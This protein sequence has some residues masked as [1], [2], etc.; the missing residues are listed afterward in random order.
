MLKYSG[1][2]SES[3]HGE[4]M[5]G[6]KR[7]KLNNPFASLQFK[8][9]RYYWIGMCISLVGTWMQNIAQPWLAYSLTKS[10]LLLSLVGTLQF[11]PVLLFSLF[12]GVVLDRFPKK[13]ILVATQ[14]SFLII[15]M[16]LT[17]L[18]M[19]G[20]IRYWHI[21]VLSTLMGFVNTFD[22]PARQAFVV[23]LIEK[24]YL[25]NAIS[26]NSMA[27]NIARIIG[28]TVAGLVMGYMGIGACFLINSISFG[29][30]L[31]GLFFV[32]PVSD[33]IE[34]KHEKNIVIIRNIG[35]GLKYIRTNPRIYW[36]LIVVAIIG[37][38]ALNNSVLVPVFT[39]EVLKQGEATFG[40]ILSIAGVGSLIG[41]LATA[42]TSSS[43]PK[44]YTI[45]IFPILI[46]LFTMLAGGSND[47]VILGMFLSTSG[48]FFII[49]SSNA[50][51]GIQMD[52][53]NQFRGRVMS[54]Y[55][56]VF[57][58]T[59]PVGNLFAGLMDDHFGPRAG[60]YACGLMIVVL[61]VVANYFN[62]PK[63]EKQN[64]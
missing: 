5:L 15:T 29:A 4:K 3:R 27:M 11:T 37:T 64:A 61:M 51:T 31:V 53:D 17:I 42:S 57:A 38:F 13:K 25:M 22:M 36:N 24:D 34:Y 33:T 43:G 48:F 14:L 55:T 7:Q 46:G 63:K 59:T 9:F 54:V 21:L 40:I 20:N 30:V 52:V 1:T 6:I 28:P 26:L 44:K 58:G 39:K 8:N 16:V 32:K 49:F 12:A 47:F 45:F 2:D 35:E 18:V 41:A 56:L 60:F 50:N 10:P 23:H 62:R 19:S